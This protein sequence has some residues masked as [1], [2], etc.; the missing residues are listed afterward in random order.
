MRYEGGKG[1]QKLWLIPLIRV[2]AGTRHGNCGPG[3]MGSEKYGFREA[4]VVIEG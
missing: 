2:V 1:L 4:L 3:S